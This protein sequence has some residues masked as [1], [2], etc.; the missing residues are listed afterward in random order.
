[1][2][3]EGPE[4][5]PPWEKSL[6]TSSAQAATTAGSPTLLELPRR[7]PGQAWGVRKQHTSQT[8]AQSSGLSGR[9]SSRAVYRTSSGNGRLS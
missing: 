2:W 1:M 7:L 8:L 6:W 5:E 3:A 4:G 9:A